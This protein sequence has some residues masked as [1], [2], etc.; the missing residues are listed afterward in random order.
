MNVTIKMIAEL[1]DVSVGTV[2]RVLNKRG[3]VR[4]EVE[5][6]VL[7]IA[8]ALNYKPNSAAKSLALRNKGIKIGVVS[9]VQPTYINYAVNE[10]YAGI[11]Q[12][13]NEYADSG[14]S[15]V[16]RYGK[17]FDVESQIAEIKS[18]ME[19]GISALAISPINDPRVC[20][21]LDELIVKG[22]PVFCFINDVVTTHTHYFIGIDNYRVGCVAAGLFDLLRKDDLRIAMVLPS[23]SLLGN[24]SRMEGFK[25]TINTSYSGHM[26][27][28]SVCIATNDDITSYTTVKKML[29]EHPEVN[30]IFFASGAAEGGMSAIREAGLLGKALI[31]AIDPSE[32]L[33]HHMKK[34]D[35]KAVISQNTREA[36]YRT[37]KLILDYILFGDL[38][39]E[40]CIVIHSDTIIKEHLL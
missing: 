9:H 27:I 38:P 40:S 34:G 37:I 18:L 22:V 12:A 17:N 39:E 11:R 24:A 23:L 36:G 20:N 3:K 10:G 16:Y 25:H 4:P 19:E 7:A 6:R 8:K 1:S 5:R 35:I 13:E 33:R 21:L 26:Q 29:M 15:L 30:A 14:I 31:V 2:D 32:T 28:E